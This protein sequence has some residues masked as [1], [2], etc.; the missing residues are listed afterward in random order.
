MIKKKPPHDTNQVLGRPSD[1]LPRI[2]P[3]SP[4]PDR[5]HSRINF[6]P[7]WP[8]EVRLEASPPPSP[9]LEEAPPA[10]AYAC[11]TALRITPV[12]G[13]Q[14]RSPRSRITSANAP[15]ATAS[16]SARRDP[17]PPFFF[18][19]NSTPSSLS[20]TQQKKTTMSPRYNIPP[21]DTA[22]DKTDPLRTPATKPVSDPIPVKQ[23]RLE[24]VRPGFLTPPQ[25]SL[26]L[27]SSSDCD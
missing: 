1:P 18:F 13:E 24:Q 10:R 14:L 3:S 2:P 23:L 16:P 5:R 22:P 25:L 9:N 26:S 11:V 8:G 12:L 27:L 17:A 19:P 15:Q 21:S 4:Q 20:A 7:C 6:S